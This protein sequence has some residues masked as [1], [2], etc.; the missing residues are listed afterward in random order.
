MSVRILQQVLLATAIAG[1]GGRNTAAQ[2]ETASSRSANATPIA[3][4]A[5]LTPAD[6]RGVTGAEVHLIARGD[7][8]GAGGTCGNYA[9]ADGAAYLGVNALETA[10]E[11]ATSVRAVPADVYPRREPV[12]GLGDEAVLMKDDT[13]MLRYLVARKG[14]RGVVLFPLGRQ[15][16]AMSDGQLRQMAERALP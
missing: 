8:P 9:T 5:I 12:A 3:G 16:R 13:G 4:C 6:I 2:Q 10:S 1:C 15:G 11:Y 14:Q 7:S